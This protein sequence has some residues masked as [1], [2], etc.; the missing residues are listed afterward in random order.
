MFIRVR[1]FCMMILAAAR[2]LVAFS[3]E[4]MLLMHYFVY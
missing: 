3:I 2:F 1:G 4:K